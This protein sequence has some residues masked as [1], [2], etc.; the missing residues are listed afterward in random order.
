MIARLLLR[1]AAW[2]SALVLAVAILAMLVHLGT[3]GIVS[4]VVEVGAWQVPWALPAI[5]VAALAYA[6][7]VTALR[8]STGA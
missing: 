3:G 4:W 8:R 7:L 6:R 2:L 1:L 5:F